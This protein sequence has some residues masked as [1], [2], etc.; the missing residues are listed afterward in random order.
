MRIS[1]KT[2]PLRPCV[3]LMR[4]SHTHPSDAVICVQSDA[5]PQEISVILRFVVLFQDV[6]R[7]AMMQLHADCSQ[8]RAY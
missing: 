1:A 8:N 7:V 4:A 5:W 3:R 2:S 6:E